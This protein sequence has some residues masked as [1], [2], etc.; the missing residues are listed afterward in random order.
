M[1]EKEDFLGKSLDK[2]EETNVVDLL[3]KLIACDEIEIPTIAVRLNIFE[4]K[5]N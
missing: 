5:N 3:L 4:E 2:V 1:K